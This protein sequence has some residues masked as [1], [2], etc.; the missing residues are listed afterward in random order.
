VIRAA[1]A[2]LLLLASPAL[3]GPRYDVD[4]IGPMDGESLAGAYAQ[5]LSAPGPEVSIRINSPGGSVF[6]TLLFIDLVR[7]RIAEKGLHTTCVV[8]AAAASAAALLLESGACMT[9]VA[10]P[11]SLLLFHGVS[12]GSGGTEQQQEDDV[13]FIRV[14]NRTLAAIIAPRIRMTVDAYLDWIRGHDRPVSSDVALELGMVDRVEVWAGHAAPK[15]E[16]PPL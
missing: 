9:R 11:G 2:A 3:A 8:T 10:E 12:G 4:V 1:L 14:L 5:V 13:N 7:D 15:Q 16:T 6:T